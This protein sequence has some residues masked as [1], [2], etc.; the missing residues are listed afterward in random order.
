MAET[1][2]KIHYTSDDDDDDDDD[3]NNNNN[4][5][6]NEKALMTIN[7]DFVVTV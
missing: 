2:R 7:K 5:N 1:S 6:N 3:D 4:N